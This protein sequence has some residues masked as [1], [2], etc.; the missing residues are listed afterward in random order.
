MSDVRPPLCGA[1]GIHVA[2][3]GE[4]VVADAHSDLPAI[5][6]ALIDA[7]CRALVLQANGTLPA[8]KVQ[9][10][11]LLEVGHW[12]LLAVQLDL[13]SLACRAGN[14]VRPL[15]HEANNIII[16][17]CHA[18]FGK[19]RPK[20]D[21]CE[22]R[23]GEIGDLGRVF[24]GHVLFICLAEPL[25]H[26]AIGRLDDEFCREDVCEFGAVTITASGH[27]FLIVIVVVTGQEVTKDQLWHIALVLLVDDHGNAFPIVHDGNATSVL[28]DGDVNQVH[29]CGVSHRVVGS[30]D[31]DLVKDL[32]E[33][34]NVVDFPVHDLACS[35]IEHEHVLVLVLRGADIR[36]RSEE[37]VLE[38]RLLLVDL[39][40]S[41]APP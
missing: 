11:V 19:V 12:Q 34:G 23:A 26:G 21:P 31:Q 25:F 20:R 9:V 8:I 39:L 1:D 38:L 30:V 6:A 36:I 37:D 29:T 41:L 5:T 16:Q 3:L 14:V 18:E 24:D 7:G 33:G 13:A 17:L 4:A 22:V 15:H 28:V 35:F 2:H 10:H 32:V 27:L 40:D